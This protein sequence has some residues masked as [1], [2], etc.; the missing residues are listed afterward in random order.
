MPGITEA[1]QHSA[2]ANASEEM[3]VPAEAHEIC[4]LISIDLRR[5]SDHLAQILSGTLPPRPQSMKPWYDS[6]NIPL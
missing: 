5:T 1:S 3:L 6:E 4:E 2:Q